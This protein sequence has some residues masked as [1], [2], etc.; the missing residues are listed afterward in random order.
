[1]TRRK[2]SLR[3][4]ANEFWLNTTI[5]KIEVQEQR[6]KAAAGIAALREML[7]VLDA[8][9]SRLSLEITEEESKTTDKNNDAFATKLEAQEKQVKPRGANMPKTQGF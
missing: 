1:M 6:K 5:N 7:D 3:G 8:E 9:T 2:D 4:T